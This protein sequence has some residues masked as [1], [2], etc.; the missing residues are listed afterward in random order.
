M[1]WWSHSFVCTLHYLVIIFICRRIWRY[2]THKMLVRYIQSECVSKIKSILSA[3]FHAIY[4]AVCIQL[5]HLAYDD[6]ENTCSLSSYHH[7]QIGNMTRLTLFRVRPWDNAMHCRSFYILISVSPL[8]MIR[9]YEWNVIHM[10]TFIF[11]KI[12]LQFHFMFYVDFCDHVYQFYC[13]IWHAKRPLTDESFHSGKICLDK[14]KW[15]QKIY[16][17]HNIPYRYNFVI[18]DVI[19]QM[20]TFSAL[21]A[22]CGGNPPVTGGFPSQRPVTRSFDDFVD[23]RLNKRLGKQSRR[24]WFETPLRSF[25]RHCIESTSKWSIFQDGVWSTKPYWALPKSKNI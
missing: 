15:I 20:K 1:M 23:L 19:Y 2:W 16:C 4:G 3:I 8:Y 7:Q 9:I 25:W 12:V 14:T 5:T 6:C 13:C 10:L 22:L 21:L 17:Y 18:H 24:R 11:N